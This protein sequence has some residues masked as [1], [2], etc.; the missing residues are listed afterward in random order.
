MGEA[1][2]LPATR[3]HAEHD[4]RELRPLLIADDINEVVINPDGAVWVERA[5]AE[6][7]VRTGHRFPPK[8]VEQLSKHLAGETMNRLGEKHPVVSGSLRAFGQVLR[9]Q[10]IVPPAVEEGASLSIRKYVSRILDVR[11]IG[12]L[13]GRQVSVEGERRA[14]LAELAKLAEAGRLPELFTKAIDQRMNILVSGGTSSG[15]TTVARALLSLTDRAE[16]LVTIEDARE[17]HLPHENSVALIAE[18]VA[19]SERT[20]AKLLVAA[21]RMRP[22]RLILGEMRGEEALAFLEAINTGHPGSI[23]TIH[24]DSP[25]LALERLTLM[26]MHVGTRQTRRDVLDYAAR[27]LDLIIQVSRR[28]GRRG[29]LEIYLPALGPSR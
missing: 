4:L 24:A 22:D 19:T 27:T 6:H 11:E 5:D 2:A 1:P 28:G 17:L 10:I 13:E 14:R 25:V 3:S 15:K 29:V 20:P 8:K 7:M 12:F 9:A 23:S 26:V 16:R 21:L 18:R